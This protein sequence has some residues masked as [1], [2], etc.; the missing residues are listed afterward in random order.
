MKQFFSALAIVFMMLI[1]VPAIASSANPL[2]IILLGPPACGKG[3]QAKLLTKNLQIPHISTGDL[4][5]ENI[6]ENTSLGKKAEGYMENGQL[7]PDSLILDMLFE[8]IA[9]PDAKK[10]YL[11]DGFPRTLLQAKA[12]EKQVA[13]SVNL[14]VINLDVPDSV[15]LQRVEE[16]RQT[17]GRSD[18]TQQIALE[19]L[20]VYRSQTA[21]LIDYYEAQKVLYRIDGQESVESINKKI[22]ALINSKFLKN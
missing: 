4:L 5:R 11:L 22:M 21:P 1:A 3:T 10:G 17:E 7:V 13:D 19:R 20:K 2:V 8:R 9:R 14:V 18:D 12:Y 15:L 6:K 16:R